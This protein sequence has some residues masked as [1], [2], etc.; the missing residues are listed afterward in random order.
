MDD[1]VGIHTI[2]ILDGVYYSE[3]DIVKDIVGKKF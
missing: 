1:T 3:M 2:D